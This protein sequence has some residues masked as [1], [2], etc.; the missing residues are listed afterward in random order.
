MIVTRLHIDLGTEAGV[1]KP[2]HGVN[3][4]PV[5]MNGWLDTSARF[6]E[7]GI[8]STI[9][10]MRS[11]RRWMCTASSVLGAGTSVRPRATS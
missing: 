5:Q 2:V 3:L 10:R 4:G 8:L 6:T 9:A 7:L 11:R 1:I